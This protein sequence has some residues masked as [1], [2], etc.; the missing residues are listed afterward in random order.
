MHSVWI[1]LPGSILIQRRFY[2]SIN[3]TVFD[4]RQVR[5]EFG[6][7]HIWCI[8][9]HSNIKCDDKRS[10]ALSLFCFSSITSSKPGDISW[11]VNLLNDETSAIFDPPAL[12]PLGSCNNSD[13]YQDENYPDPGFGNWAGGDIIDQGGKPLGKAA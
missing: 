2:T 6:I 10:T 8:G 11:K 4:F 3:P 5:L 7:R 12:F 9:C 13:I 1:Y